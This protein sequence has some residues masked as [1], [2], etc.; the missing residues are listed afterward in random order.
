MRRRPKKPTPSLMDR[1]LWSDPD[2]PWREEHLQ[3][4]IVIRLRQAGVAIEVGMEGVR[5]SKS[6]RGKAKLQGMEPGRCDLKVLL[7]G[8]V[9]VHIELKRKGG[10]VSPEQKVWHD[11]LRALGFEVHVVKASCPQ[12][13]IEEVSKI[14]RPHGVE[15][16]ADL[17]P[18]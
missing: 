8:G 13:A 11:R 15:L 18:G 5:L 12:A 9:T 1:A 3:A 17:T 14:L 6:Q 10:R 2:A 4:A 7:Q 16:C